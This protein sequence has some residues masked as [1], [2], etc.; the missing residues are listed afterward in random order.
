MDVEDYGAVAFL[1]S[2]T[3]VNVRITVKGTD[4]AVCRQQLNSASQQFETRLGSY[5]YAKENMSMPTIVQNLLT[6]KQKTLAVTDAF[7][8]GKILEWLTPNGTEKNGYNGGVALNP[9]THSMPAFLQAGNPD[10]YKAYRTPEQAECLARAARDAFSA[11]YGLALLAENARDGQI[12][13]VYYALVDAQETIFDEY[14]IRKTRTDN[15]K[16]AAQF[17]LNLI[18][19]HLLSR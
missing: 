18:R 9:N 4:I 5:V 13:K 17:G 16:R 7:T 11:S 10:R 14:E 8:G 15:S 6:K 12:Y 19:K 2:F 1:P 3:G